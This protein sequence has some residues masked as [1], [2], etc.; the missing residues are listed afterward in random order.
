MYFSNEEDK[1][2]DD[3]RVDFSY[4]PDLSIERARNVSVRLRGQHGRFVMVQLFF[5]AKWILLSEVT[6]HSEPYVERP[7]PTP[8]TVPAGGQEGATAPQPPQPP[9]SPSHSS[10]SSSSSPPSAAAPSDVSS[11]HLSNGDHHHGD[12]QDVGSRTN[13]G[14]ASVV[15]GVLLA[16]VLALPFTIL[17]LVGRARRESGGG[18]SG[19]VSAS[20]LSGKPTHS[21]L[22]KKLAG[23]FNLDYHHPHSHHD[24]EAPSS[25]SA[26]SA[27]TATKTTTT[28][29]S[30]FYG[31][32]QHQH[33]IP[34]DP[35]TQETIYEE[36]FSSNQYN[37]ASLQP[38]MP[39]PSRLYS[40]S[41]FLSLNPHSQNQ[42]LG[43]GGGPRRFGSDPG[44]SEDG[45]T[46]IDDDEEEDEEDY[47]EPMV[48]A[49][50]GGG[51]NMKRFPTSSSF[52]ENMYATAGAPSAPSA[53]QHLS[54]MSHHKP[55]QPAASAPFS[56]SST[57]VAAVNSSP[58]ARR[59]ALAL[60]PLP[61]SHYARPGTPPQQQQQQQPRRTST[62]T[63]SPRR[64]RRR[65]SET[66]IAAEVTPPRYQTVAGGGRQQQQQQQ[67]HPPTTAMSMLLPLP[68][69]PP[70]PNRTS[71]STVARSSHLLDSN[72]NG[73]GRPLSPFSDAS[74]PDIGSCRE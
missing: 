64:V 21:L 71:A 27:S 20:A 13:S 61:L 24:H 6:F 51:G 32:A 7:Y 58:V 55:L 8:P 33:P 12:H 3:R 41:G 62:G 4:M 5:A 74:R 1:F 14:D 19:G 59:A 16:V 30:S 17:Y 2:G 34:A 39:H 47:A 15:V 52:G 26:A 28:S 67:K 44:L 48:G 23:R 66:S 36:P 11:T 43:G 70:P 65:Q 54:S 69:P 45:D 63:G 53:P 68:P 73:S 9:L 42:H 10:S 38:I 46:F 49:G 18:G 50:G 29:S 31:G 56:S 72:A 35:H 22:T 25:S 40:S 57:A 60:K 37:R